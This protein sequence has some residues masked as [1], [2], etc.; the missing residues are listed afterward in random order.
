MPWDCESTLTAT[1]NTET[2]ISI[3]APKSA[4]HLTDYMS[5]VA[6]VAPASSS[7]LLL[8]MGSTLIF[9]MTKTNNGCPTLNKRS[10][11]L[12]SCHSART[13]LI[14]C[15]SICRF[16]LLS[17]HIIINCVC[18]RARLPSTSPPTCWCYI[19]PC[20]VPCQQVPIL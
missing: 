16:W 9:K 15:F 12:C 13:E 6:A 3:A 8:L 7:R 18:L 20:L 2:H 10:G 5:G 19:R 14:V 4:G 1:T 11:A 17:C